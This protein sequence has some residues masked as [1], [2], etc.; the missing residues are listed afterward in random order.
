MDLTPTRRRT[1]LPLALLSAV[2]F[3][4]SGSF[5]GALMAAGWSPG[6]AVTLRIAL[7]ALLLTG[8]A[9]WQ[10]R[11]RWQLLRSSFGVVVAFALLAVVGSQLFFFLAVQRIPVGVALLLEYCGVLLV[12][13]W[14]WWRRGQRPG[15]LTRIGSATAVIGLAVLLRAHDGLAL[16]P[17]GVAFGL[18]AAAGLAGFYLLSGGANVALPP[19]AL[20]WA[21]MVVAAVVLVLAGAGG[22]LPFH[23]T[24]ADVVLAGRPVS[25][26]VPVLGLVVLS[27]ALSYVTGIA[28]ARQ[29]RPRLA[30]SLGL[31]EVLFA[32]ATAWLL[33]GQRPGGW[34]VVGGVV[35]LAGVALVHADRTGDRAPD[36]ALG[37]DE[38]TSAPTPAIR[39]S[40]VPTSPS[41][42]NDRIGTTTPRARQ[43]SHHSR[44]A[45]EAHGVMSGPALVPISSAA[46]RGA[47]SATGSS[48]R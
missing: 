2:L 38:S 17:L 14:L 8:P 33:L 42:T 39:T 27:T 30:S 29:L 16:E 11:T 46:T 6:A 4:T 28:A 26:V 43:R 3:G 32:A 1:S 45:S 36:R 10:L 19:L 31:T 25:W 24:T 22:L 41:R 21:G 47:A 7:A 23:A 18:L 35:V 5:A 34:Q 13:G 20:A 12:V 15:P 44:V 37:Q 40:G 9:A 48:A